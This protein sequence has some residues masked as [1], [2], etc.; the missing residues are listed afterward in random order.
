MADVVYKIDPVNEILF[1]FK[2]K[3]E[4]ELTGI[5]ELSGCRHPIQSNTIVKPK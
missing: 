5:P 2:A 1:R 4:G 3:H